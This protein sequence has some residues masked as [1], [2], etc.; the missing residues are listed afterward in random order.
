MIY[1][2]TDQV[3]LATGP[4]P[5]PDTNYT[6]A[7][8]H[9]DGSTSLARGANLTGWTTPSKFVGV[10]W[11]KLS[12][13]VNGIFGDNDQFLDGTLL[14]G[15]DKYHFLQ[16]ADTYCD[17]FQVATAKITSAAWQCFLF[18]CDLTDSPAIPR[19][20]LFVGD[21]DGENHSDRGAGSSTSLSALSDFWFGQDGVGDFITG[22]IADVRFWIDQYMDF[23]IEANRRYFIRPNGK[24]ADPTYANALLGTPIISFIGNSTNFPTNGGSGGAFSLTGSLTN[25]G[26]SPT[27]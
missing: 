17:S 9:F 13:A 8:V 2:I 21:T 24:P 23:T 25:A 22:D 5:P 14:D 6:T 15:P 11:T 27:D 19:I 3:D 18:S 16:F 1:G 10:M 26:T 20:N 7:A 4:Q 12:A